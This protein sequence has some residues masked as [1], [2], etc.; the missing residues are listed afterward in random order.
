LYPEAYYAGWEKNLSVVLCLWQA[1]DCKKYTG[2]ATSRSTD[3]AQQ[4]RISS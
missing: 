4:C 2:S 1:V 3:L